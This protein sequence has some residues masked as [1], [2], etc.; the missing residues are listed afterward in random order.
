MA[1]S[2]WRELVASEHNGWKSR[3]RDTTVHSTLCVL[4][5]LIDSGFLPIF[6]KND[7]CF[8]VN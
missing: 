5:I 8:S 4:G 2:F 3:V 6:T 7:V 1:I